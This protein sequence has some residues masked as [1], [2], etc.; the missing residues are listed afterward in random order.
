MLQTL[1]FA[2]AILNDLL[3]SNKNTQRNSPSIIKRIQDTLF[4]IA[5]PLA[6]YV[7]STFWAIY[8]YER[9]LIFPRAFDAFFPAW[10]NQSMHTFILVFILIELLTS[11]RKYPSRVF[12]ITLIVAFNVTYIWWVYNIYFK[13][14]FW[15]YPI[16]NVLDSYARI[17]FFFFSTLYSLALYVVGEKLNNVIWSKQLKEKAKS[18]KKK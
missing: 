12:G 9:E 17:A 14:E 3:G 1:Y 16:L 10:L 13:Y 18:H 6:V 2:A 8:A 15:V 11:Y 4:I 7:A 5:F